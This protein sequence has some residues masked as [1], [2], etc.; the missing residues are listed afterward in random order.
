MSFLSSTIMK[1]IVSEVSGAD[2]ETSVFQRCLSKEFTPHS[3]IAAHVLRGV[4]G[5][6]GGTWLSPV[7]FSGFLESNWM[8]FIIERVGNIHSIN[9]SEWKQLELFLTW[10]KYFLNLIHVFKTFCISGCFACMH[11]CVCLVPEEARRGCSIPWPWVI[12][13]LWSAGWVLRLEPGLLEEQPALLTAE[14]SLLPWFTYCDACQNPTEYEIPVK[15]WTN[16]S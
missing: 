1:H 8:P 14:P 4:L 2:T 12:T 13:D 16:G 7:H 9:S 5:V 11:V 6:C 15:F 10:C 3:V